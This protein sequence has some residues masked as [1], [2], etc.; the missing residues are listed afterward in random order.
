MLRE[1]QVRISS[2]ETSL[3]DTLTVFKIR[4][5]NCPYFCGKLK[6][7]YHSRSITQ[8]IPISSQIDP[9]DILTFWLFAIYFNYFDSVL[10]SL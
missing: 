7:H 10:Q 2:K 5:N 6:F 4:I 1:K 9:V 8:M 3:L